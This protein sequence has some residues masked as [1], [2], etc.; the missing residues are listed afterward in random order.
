M[1]GG[2]LTIEDGATSFEGLVLPLIQHIRGNILVDIQSGSSAEA[3][4]TTAMQVLDFG[5]ELRAID[6][7]F[8]VRLHLDGEDRRRKLS[9]ERLSCT[10]LRKR[11]VD[12]GI[13][14]GRFDCEIRANGGRDLNASGNVGGAGLSIELV[15]LLAFVMSFSISISGDMPLPV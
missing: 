1:L 11:L 15:V 4:T 13:L 3:T 9:E 10:G 2:N 5:P 8:T 12:S 7:D 14:R 6:G